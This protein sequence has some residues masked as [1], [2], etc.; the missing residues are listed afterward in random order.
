[1]STGSIDQTGLQNEGEPSTFPVW[2]E[3]DLFRATSRGG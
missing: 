3:E 1:M 2:E